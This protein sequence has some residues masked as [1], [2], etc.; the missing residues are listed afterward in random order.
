[1]K[2]IPRDLF[3]VSDDLESTSTLIYAQ[4]PCE[5][6]SIPTLPTDNGEID[7]VRNDMAPHILSKHHC[8]EA[9][10][11]EHESMEEWRKEMLLKKRI[12]T[13]GQ[14]E[15]NGFEVTQVK[16]SAELLAQYKIKRETR[17]AENNKMTSFRDQ[18]LNNPTRKNPIMIEED[19]CE[20]LTRNLRKKRTI[21]AEKNNGGTYSK[22]AA[23]KNN[24]GTYSK[25][26]AEKNTNTG[27]RSLS[28]E[29]GSS[30]NGSQAR[31]DGV[32]NSIA[33]NHT[34]SEAEKDSTTKT[35]TFIS[36]DTSSDDEDD[37]DPNKKG[38]SL[39]KYFEVHGINVA[40]EEDEEE[41]EDDDE[42][43]AHDEDAEN[44]DGIG[45]QSN[46]QGS[47]LA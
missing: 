24:G 47:S 1:M 31:D 35:N 44:V 17:M 6:E 33:G 41:E 36:N 4:E 18:C 5:S 32:N 34:T 12:L 7:L 28:K 11:S 42:E 3:R 43:S 46:N 39:D 20:D 21:A 19:A 22:V 37:T 30:K 25:V 26:A 23:E 8:E 14:I 15:D 29:Q 38:M 2:T 13:L 27:N 45:Q 40:V 16:S 9:E 10:E